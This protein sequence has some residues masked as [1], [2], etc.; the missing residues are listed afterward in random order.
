VDIIVVSGPPGSGKTTVSR[1]LASHA[2]RGVHLATDHFFEFLPNRLDPSLPGSE[3]QNLTI[4][5]AWCAAAN[6]YSAGGYAVFIDGVI[7]PWWFENLKAGFGSFRYALL[8]ADLETCLARTQSRSGQPEANPDVVR[9]MHE[10]FARVESDW[11]A[12]VIDATGDVEAVASAVLAA[13]RVA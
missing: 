3:Q 5:N 12:H 13:P 6:A 2:A 8:M 4:L 1:Y 11:I 7:G 9:R 10:Q